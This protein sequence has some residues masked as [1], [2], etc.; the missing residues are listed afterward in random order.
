MYKAASGRIP[1]RVVCNRAAAPPLI[2][3]GCVRV[4]VR[5]RG[6]G[7]VRGQ[8][9]WVHGRASSRVRRWRR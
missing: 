3:V 6:R 8:V 2:V 4:L 5:G 7:R 1:P 9:S